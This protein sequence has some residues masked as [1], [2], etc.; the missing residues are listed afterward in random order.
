VLQITDDMAKDVK[1]FSGGY[2]N[3]IS[4]RALSQGN[5]AIRRRPRPDDI[6]VDSRSMKEYQLIVEPPGH[7]IPYDRGSGGKR[8]R[9]RRPRKSQSPWCKRMSRIS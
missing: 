1:D 4:Y 2:S 8:R 3:S 6:L 9:H 7:G 5:F